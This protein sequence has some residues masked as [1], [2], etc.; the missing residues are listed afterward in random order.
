LGEIVASKEPAGQQ[1]DPYAK[2]R[3]DLD[4]ERLLLEK[5]RLAADIRLKRREL[6]SR[7]WFREAMSN[8][9]TLAVA[10]GIITLMIQIITTQLNTA[11]Q[12]DAD[13]REASAAR[14]ADAREASEAREA[15]KRKAEAAAEADTR[16]SEASRQ[17]QSRQLQADLIKQFT[18]S[19]VETSR[20][21]L[22]FL[23][24]TG[25]LPDFREAI[26]EYLKSNPGGGPVD[27]TPDRGG[28]RLCSDR[29]SLDAPAISDFTASEKG[30]KDQCSIVVD[31]GGAQYQCSDGK[32]TIETPA[33]YTVSIVS[34]PFFFNKCFIRVAVP[35]EG[36]G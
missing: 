23:V 34:P 32:I 10:G 15:D 12:R 5:R 31:G 7:S 1:P 36:P 20:S 16:A 14:E 3:L 2:D 22:E 18:T 4:R 35:P 17:A 29:V 9:L 27:S 26:E 13:V 11:A 28:L 30:E 19:S 33:N 6:S 24:Q 8:P 25:L 21:N